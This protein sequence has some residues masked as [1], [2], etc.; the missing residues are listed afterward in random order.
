MKLSVKAIA[1]FKQIYQSQFQIELTDD[2][3]N[4]KALE[5]LEYFQY[6]SKPIP[7]ENEPFFLSLDVDNRASNQAM[8]K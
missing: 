4:T 1:D 5:L 3:A 6:M 8:Y 7:N 2:E